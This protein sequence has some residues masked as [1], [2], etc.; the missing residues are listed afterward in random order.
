[1]RVVQIGVKMLLASE[2]QAAEW[3]VIMAG[4]LITMIPPLIVLLFLQRSFVKG[5]AMQQEK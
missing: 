5:F 3:N 4:T 1:M 2:E